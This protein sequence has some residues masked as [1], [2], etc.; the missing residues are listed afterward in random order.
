MAF[1]NPL[2]LW[3]LVAAALPI[4]IHLFYRRRPR[5]TP[6]AA[7][8]FILRARRET[9]RRLR[10]K[11]LLLFVARTALLAA[12]ALALARPRAVTQRA[13][14]AATRVGPAAVAVVLDASGS[15]GYRL[16]GR[17][18]FDRARSDA[19]EALEALSG[20]EPA[21]A[22][23]C[24]GPAV[25]VAPPPGFDRLTVRRTLRDAE[26]G[27][28]YADLTACV[29]A[30][31]RALSDPA[32]GG[33]AGRRIVVAT[34]LTASAWRLDAPPP[35]VQTPAGAV[36]PEVTLLDAARG[37]PLPNSAV[38]DL[39][40]EPDPAVG[41]RGYRI[42]VAIAHRGKEALHDVPFL[43]RVGSG[44]GVR[45]PIR[46]FADLPANGTVK[47]TLS[48]NFA[49]GG[50]L[51]ISVALDQDALP[52]D[53]V[54]WLALEVP[55]EVRA[56]VVD[57]SPSPVR[58][59]DEAFFVEAALASPASPA[60]P[61][62]VDA[63]A[64]AKVRFADFDEIFLLNVRSLGQRA[65]ELAAFVEGGGGLFVA[66][67]DEVD[68][69]VYDAELGKVLPARLHLVKTAAER[70][71]P[72]AAERAARFA[73]VDWGHPALSIFSGVAREGFE[74]VRTFRYMLLKPPAKSPLDAPGTQAKGERAG[75]EAR[76]ERPGGDPNAS[77]IL[78]R[79]DDGAPAL[80]E[81]RR[82][83]GRVILYTSTVDREWSD[84]T[85][86]TSFLPAVQR[87]AAYL[88]GG[89]SERK[90]SPSVVDAPRVVLAEEGQKLLALVSPDG[91]E[92]TPPAAPQGARAGQVTFV[93]D[94]PGLW[95][96]KVQEGGAV[97]L[98][99]RLAFSVLPDPRES[100]TTRIDPT[101][102]TAW[103]GGASHAKVAGD[104]HAGA[105]ERSVPLWSI[106]LALAVVAFL[107]EGLLVA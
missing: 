33:T 74:G 60:R 5:P 27:A 99:P 80:I 62:V 59:R 88:A 52:I 32:A 34:D 69:D 57:G 21:T 8:D 93:P 73:E 22:L 70:D 71:A 107:G 30:A 64:L 55:R 37:A 94:Q 39:A 13:A 56:L 29:A 105:G 76:S 6:F 44:P 18:L 81:A 12:A 7:I 23:V 61:T 26:P 77:R 48:Y 104:A 72:G 91:R 41:P 106:L 2:L 11:K 36:R 83:R 40:A 66:L 31:A 20:E 53:D 38:T 49:A 79:Y 89:L 9:E 50:P 42:T 15:M 102:L 25:P 87:I 101:E 100:D 63:E 45:T 65:G 75:V 24:G 92:R 43:L 46:A 1:G 68:P 95:Q 86:R 51:A 67:G 90:S 96:V 58:Y 10:I 84:W 14:A 17:T 54:R 103:L 19:L 98:D 47:K 97:K 3:G 4:L 16:G 28:G 35:M 82:G 78:V 85:I